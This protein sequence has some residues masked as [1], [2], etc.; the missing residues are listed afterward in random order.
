MGKA[1]AGWAP[2]PSLKTQKLLTRSLSWTSPESILSSLPTQTAL[3]KEFL[4]LLDLT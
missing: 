1:A 4:N 2:V 3:P